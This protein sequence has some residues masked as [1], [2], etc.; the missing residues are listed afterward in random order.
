MVV[1]LRVESVTEDR[2]GARKEKRFAYALGRPARSVLY[3]RGVDSEG[4]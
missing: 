3:I 1:L 4:D 2:E